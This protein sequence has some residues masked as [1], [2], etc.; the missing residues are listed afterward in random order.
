MY[1]GIKQATGPNMKKTAPLKTKCGTTISD[2]QKQME[3]WVEHY[4]ELYSTENTVSE[5]AINSIPALSVLEE[6]DTEPTVAEL[7][8]AIDALACGKAPG[9]DAIPPEVIK[10]GKPAL[11][12]H[13]QELLCLCW[14]EGSVPQ[15]MRDAKIVTLFKNKGDRSVCDNYRC[16]SLLSIVGKVFTRVVLSRLQVLADRVYPETQCGF[17]AGR[18]TI[19]MVFSV[20]QLQEKCREQ[21]QPLYLAFVDLTKAFDLVSRSG[22]FRLLERIGCPP[23]L[24]NII[25]SFHDNM[26]STVSF[27]GNTSESFPV[28]SGVKQGCVLAPTLFGIFF[29]LLLSYA[30]RSSDDG[31]YIHTRH[32]GKLFNLARL[33]A[34]TKTI[35]VLLRE[36]LF[37]DDAA[38]ASHSEQGLQRLLDCFSSTCH[39]FSL[40]ISIKKTVVMA[41]N[42]PSPPLITVNGSRLVVVEKFTY[43]GSTVTHNLSLDTEIN[44]RI[45]RAAS[46]MSKLKLRV[47]ENKNLSVQTKLR[48]YEACVLGTLLYGSETW[49]TYA[50]QEAKL[51]AFHMRCLRRILGI[52]WMD[53]VTNSEVL[54]RSRSRSMY[55]ILSERRLRWLGHVRRMDRDRI[56][57]DLLYGQLE[58]GTR[59][60]GRP[61]LRYKD[62]CKR[63]FRAAYI[64][65]ESWE[66]IALSRTLWRST[67]KTGV[68]RADEDRDRLRKEKR[69]KQKTQTVQHTCTTTFICEGCSRDCHSRIGL[70]SHRRTC[71][72]FLSLPVAFFMKVFEREWYGV[73]QVCLEDFPSED[74][75]RAYIIYTV[76]ISYVIPLTTSVVCHCLILRYLATMAANTS[77]AQQHVMARKKKVTR[78]VATV[79][80]LFAVCWAPNHVLNLWFAFER[81]GLNEV[82]HVVMWLKIT[83]LCLSYANSSVN[84]FVYGIMGEN[85][86][87]AFAKSFKSAESSGTGSAMS[88]KT[89]K[90]TKEEEIGMVKMGARR[91]TDKKK[92]PIDNSSELDQNGVMNGRESRM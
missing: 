51:N 72:F 12:P 77:V 65:I 57:K 61:H 33:R 37:A 92:T 46:V 16:I 2:P 75:Y 73:K 55:A 71:S 91:T 27:E 70:H 74:E 53:R 82:P 5:E 1:E 41:Q 69:E 19:D 84:P 87:K 54:R 85:F 21:N 58:C 30:F 60:K 47:W 63:D 18:S 39:E 88:P 38:L 90:F 20:R 80:I 4:L 11:L 49:T 44:T 25:R 52:T 36:L 10:Q 43:L 22:L 40:T 13:L 59:K 6:L 26:R 81:E 29:S 3:R 23:K 7:E 68:K 78:M 42:A 32:D 35:R 28:L 15:D 62:A 64:D 83:A 45:G 9:N 24:L 79:V 8:K 66:S 56:P 48:V 86:K 14:K 50:A 67:V 89:P 31:V 76:L 17:R 34:K